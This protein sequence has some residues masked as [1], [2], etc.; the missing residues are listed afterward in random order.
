MFVVATAGHVD[1]GKSTLVK[2]LTGME[3]DRWADERRRGL[4]IDLG[5]VWTVLPSGREVGFVDVPGHERFL[6]NMLAGL[7]P[8]PVV[9][10]VVAADEGWR[11]QS[12]DHRDALAAWGVDHGVVVISRADRAT[13]DRIAEVTEQ[14]RAELAGTG[15]AAAPVVAVS[16][17]EGTGLDRLRQVLDEVLAD[18]T[19]A[20]DGQ[21]RLWVD[22]SFTITGAGT[23]VTG[24]LT[25][26][27]LH[28]GDR[29]EL[30]GRNGRREVTVRGLQSHG[31]SADRAEP[32]SRVAVNLRGIAHDEIHRGDALLAAGPWPTT[33]VVDV[34]RV[35]GD[36][37]VPEWLTVHVGT[38]AAP[39]RA[40]MLDRDHFRLTLSRE[41]PLRRDD[42]LVLRDPGAGR[43]VGGVAVLDVDPP[44]LRRRGDGARRG[45][46]LA[47]LDDGSGGAAAEVAR[48]TAVR[49]DRLAELGVDTATVPADVEVFDEWWLAPGVMHGW[50]M[51]LRGAVVDLHERDPLAA[52]LTDGA[53]RG[54]LE[55]P[56][57]ALMHR[58]ID[59]AGVTSS[60]GLLFLPEQRQNLG[61]AER[62]VVELERRLAEQP[63]MAPEADDLA[64]LKL[65]TRE[66]AAAERVGRLLRLADGV[67]VQPKAPARAMREL[68]RLPQPFTTSQARQA[69]GTSRR[70]AI[71]LLE[72]LDG[73]GWT[74]RLDAGHREVVR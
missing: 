6:P 45:Q 5:F 14:V 61:P 67:V 11:E 58:V 2:A 33:A 36:G 51:R 55:L 72:H 62:G 20:D 39:A 15:L 74:R 26:G 17:M 9:C 21:V 19:A 59:G 8:A 52:G 66:L 25:A 56:D 23:V 50:Q 28:P 53:A 27:S 54:L 49:R 24:T 64:E 44:D 48:R 13:A 12:S 35:T 10:F 30:F 22:R 31:R 57:G 73:K 60:G 3:P 68:A 71:P 37:D 7:G 34:R 32:V 46:S 29:L 4:T 16:A 38:A 40:R 1:H 18:S 47:G 42:R 63:F 43:I 65:G 41:L 70:V 69:L